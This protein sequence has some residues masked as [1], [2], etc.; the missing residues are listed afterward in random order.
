MSVVGVG[1]RHLSKQGVT[2]FAVKYE[3][4]GWSREESRIFQNIKQAQA[5]AEDVYRDGGNARIVTIARG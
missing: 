3:L 4:F 5:Y 1:E 2:M